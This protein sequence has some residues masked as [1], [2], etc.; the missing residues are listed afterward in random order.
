MIANHP[1]FSYAG[2]SLPPAGQL[3]SVLEASKEKA[4]TSVMEISEKAGVALDSTVM[5]VAWLA[6]PD[7]FGFPMAGMKF[8]ACANRW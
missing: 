7:L 5:A 8:S 4:E 6:K 1:L 2:R 3:R